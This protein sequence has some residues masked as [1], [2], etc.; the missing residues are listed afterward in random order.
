V[1]FGRKLAIE[2]LYTKSIVSGAYT[3]IVNGAHWIDADTNKRGVEVNQRE[4]FSSSC[5]I[6]SEDVKHLLGG[7]TSIRNVLE[8]SFYNIGLFVMVQCPFVSHIFA[9]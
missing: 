4:D 6:R 9:P 7:W 1:E 5:K 3:N 2:W 8:V